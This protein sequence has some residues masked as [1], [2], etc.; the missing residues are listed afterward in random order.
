MTLP[1]F[2][3]RI[4]EDMLYAGF[5]QLTADAVI[6]T[7]KAPG[8]A[9][10]YFLLS[11][12]V[13]DPRFGLDLAGGTTPPTRATLSWTQLNLP[14]GAANA[15]LPA[16]PSVPDAS[17]NPAT[18]TAAAMANLVR[19]RPFRAFLHGSLLLRPVT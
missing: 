1:A 7:P 15:T 13:S 4:G 5:A 18:A 14:S 12:N 6:G 9:G 8:S 10:S 17:F 16:F 3:G 2:R 19:Q 11:E